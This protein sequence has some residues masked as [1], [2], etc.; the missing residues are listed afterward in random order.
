MSLTEW[1]HIA[2]KQLQDGLKLLGTVPRVAEEAWEGK[3]AAWTE[4]RKLRYPLRE[5]PWD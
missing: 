5:L 1:F 2:T 4:S 3:R